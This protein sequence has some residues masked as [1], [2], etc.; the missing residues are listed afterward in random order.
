MLEQIQVSAPRV[1]PPHPLHAHA[2]E[3]VEREGVTSRSTQQDSIIGGAVLDGPTA[4]RLQEQQLSLKLKSQVR[5]RPFPIPP[6]PPIPPHCL[7]AE[8]QWGE[9]SLFR[10]REELRAPV[11]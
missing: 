5:R 9:L 2:G 11:V 6:P 1:L 8:R 4:S 3:G 7:S 10:S